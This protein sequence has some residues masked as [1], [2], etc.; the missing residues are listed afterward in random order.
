MSNE[1]YRKINSSPSL[2]NIL[3]QMEDF[4]DSLD[5]Y[6]YQNWD[7]GIVVDGPN[8]E[9]YWVSMILKY[10]YHKMP[11][12]EG[13]LRLTKHG[14]KV[15]YE[16]AKEEIPVEIESSDDFRDGTK[17]PKMEQI[18]IWLVTVQIPK[19]YIEELDSGDLEYNV[20]ASEV[21]IDSVKD[22]RDD[23]VES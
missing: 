21:D 1:L 11:N 2:L 15:F 13:A 19:K 20:D 16:K 23:N 7:E 18:D 14:A 4:M 8:I 17:K 12:P 3:I 10:D 22:A 9:R 6:V 5:L